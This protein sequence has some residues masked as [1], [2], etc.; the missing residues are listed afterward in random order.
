MGEK[1]FIIFQMRLGEIVVAMTDDSEPFD[2]TNIE[3]LL[4]DYPALIVPMPV[5]QG[6]QGQPGQI[7][8]QKYFPFSEQKGGKIRK[9][10]IISLSTPIDNFEKAYDGWVTQVKAQ[11]SG[12]ILAK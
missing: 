3:I 11:E 1:F 6:Q 2:D 10:E 5:Q 8:F 12:I 7:A 9:S 4:V